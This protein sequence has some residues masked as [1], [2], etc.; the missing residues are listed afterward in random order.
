MSIILID[1]KSQ[2]AVLEK[3]KQVAQRIVMRMS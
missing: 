3:A 2:D 1:L